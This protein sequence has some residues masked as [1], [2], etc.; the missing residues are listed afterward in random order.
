MSSYWNTSSSQAAATRRKCFISYYSRDRSAVDDFLS[1]FDDVL[2]PKA[3]GVSDGDDFVDS[4]DSDYVMTRIRQKYLGDSSVTICL[5]GQCTHSRRYIDWELKASLRQGSYTPNGLLGILLPA[6]GD[7]GILP[8]RFEE[9]WN[10]NESLGYALYRSYPSTSAVLRGWIEDAYS[11]RTTHSHF[12][13]N[14]QTMF[15]YN[16]VCEVHRV[17]H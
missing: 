16:H 9:N 11:R 12:I 7:S 1:S 3:I 8:P 5:I 10:S 13:R 2:I 15:K 17:T 14:A 6:M 4:D